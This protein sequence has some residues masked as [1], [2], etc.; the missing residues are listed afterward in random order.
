M[1]RCF[2]LLDGLD[3]SFCHNPSRC[4]IRVPRNGVRLGQVLYRVQLSRLV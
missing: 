1:L 2:R 3:I 4:R